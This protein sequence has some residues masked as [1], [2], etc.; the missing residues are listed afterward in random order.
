MKKLAI[1]ALVIACASG[2]LAQ[3]VILEDFENGQNNAQWTWQMWVELVESTGGN[4][5]GYFHAP[6]MWQ[7]A[8]ILYSG[9]MAPGWSGNF[10][11]DHVTRIEGDFKVFS[12]GTN[13]G[14]FPFCVMLRNSMGTPNNIEDDV[15]VYTDPELLTAPGRG[16]P[17][18]HYSFNIPSD[19]VGQPGQLPPGWMGGTYQICNTCFPPNMTFQQ[20]I[21]GVSTVEFWFIHPDWAANIVQYNVGADNL[22]I[23]RSSGPVAV[24]NSNWGN[25][26]SMFR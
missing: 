3:G 26:K 11:A 9:Y 23:E 1:V 25:V 8:P 13:S 22:L 24:E 14:L 16:A 5:G 12:A 20:V 21:S 2:A 7:F 17:W 6:D 15:Y 19:F 10:V 18:K 4:P